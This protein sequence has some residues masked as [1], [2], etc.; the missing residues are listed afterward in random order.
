MT[1]YLKSI[2]FNNTQNFS[3]SAQTNMLIEENYIQ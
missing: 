3:K 1:T 2:C